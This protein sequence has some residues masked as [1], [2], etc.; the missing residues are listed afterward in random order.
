[1]V[2]V[3]LVA[4]LVGGGEWRGREWGWV[5]CKELCPL[6]NLLEMAL[7]I[8]LETKWILTCPEGT[9]PLP[10][11]LVGE[12]ETCGPFSTPHGLEPYLYTR[13]SEH[14]SICPKSR[15]SLF[16]LGPLSWTLFCLT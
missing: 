2:V 9:H 4:A 7:G 10:A 15:V 16:G 5:C 8:H 14:H 12:A 13:E 11:W 6:L 1:M 3:V